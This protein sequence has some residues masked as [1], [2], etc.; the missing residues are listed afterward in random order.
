[1]NGTRWTFRCHIWRSS[2]INLVTVWKFIWNAKI[3]TKRTSQTDHT[4]NNAFTFKTKI[5]AQWYLWKKEDRA[6]YFYTFR[7]H[8]FLRCDLWI[9][10]NSLKIYPF[11]WTLN[12]NQLDLNK[13]GEKK[14]WNC[15]CIVWWIQL[16]RISSC[17]L[18]MKLKW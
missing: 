1:M 10:K 16:I 18:K 14:C 15:R 12:H 8:F 2:I 7:Y 4:T 13:F 9:I 5:L 6:R 17:E 3:I 11:R